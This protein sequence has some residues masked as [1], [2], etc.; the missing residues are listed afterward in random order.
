MGNLFPN[1]TEYADALAPIAK[2]K[3]IDVHFMHL[4]TKIDK[5]NRIATFKNTKTDELIHKEYDMLHVVPPHSAP[6]F[7]AKSSLAAPNGWLDVNPKS[8]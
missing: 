4:L 2:S 7:V 6:D 8:L 3:D 5:D 1:C